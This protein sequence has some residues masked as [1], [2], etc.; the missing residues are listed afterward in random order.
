MN[1]HRRTLLATLALALA[2]A[3]GA[4][5]DSALPMEPAAETV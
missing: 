2:A 4:C 3:L 5:D 1:G